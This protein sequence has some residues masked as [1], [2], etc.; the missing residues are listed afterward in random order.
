MATTV[1]SNRYHQIE[2]EVLPAVLSVEEAVAKGGMFSI[3]QN[4]RLFTNLCLALFPPI[5][6]ATIVRGDIEEGFSH[7]DVIAAG[8]FEIGGAFHWYL[9]YTYSTA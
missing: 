1:E 5:P 3:Q 7:S 9:V 2:Y 8:K 6:E 4:R